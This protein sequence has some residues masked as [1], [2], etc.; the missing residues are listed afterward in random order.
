[1]ELAKVTSKGQITI[2]KDIREKLNI[3]TGDKVIFIEEGNKIVFANSS[4]VALKEIQKEFE[5]KAT[6]LGIES[7][8]AI[9]DFV[10]DIRK[11]I[12]EKKYANND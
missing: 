2:P 4:V 5:G 6:E 1:M 3:K 10:G 8:E 11:E 12:W 9:V 7:D